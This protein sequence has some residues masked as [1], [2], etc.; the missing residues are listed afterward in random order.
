M[1]GTQNHEIPTQRAHHTSQSKTSISH[2]NSTSNIT[3]TSISTAPTPDNPNASFNTLGLSAQVMMS[4]RALHYTTPTPV[5][6]QA[7]PAILEGR[8]VCAAA[9]TGTGKTAA[10]LL[11][12]LTHLPHG[13]HIRLP[14][15][16]G[17]TR[18]NTQNSRKK[19]G[20]GV[21][22]G[23]SSCNSKQHNNT[24][25]TTAQAP[26]L[27]DAATP[28]LLVITPT[29]ELAEQIGT[30]CATICRNT[31]HHLAV[32]YGG[33]KYPPQI[34]KLRCGVDILI[35]TPGR[36]MDLRERGVIDLSRVST[37]VLDEADRMLDM[38]FWPAVQSIIADIPPTRQTLLFSATLDKKILAKIQPI[39]HNPVRIEIITHGDTAKTVDQ[40]ILP[41][42]HSQ[43]QELLHALLMEKGFEKVIVFART[44]HR[45]EHC[46]K[47][48]QREKFRAE[49][50]HSDKSQAN[51]RKALENF[52]K[53][54]TNILVATDVLARGIDVPQV[55]YVVNF[56]LPDFPDD[57]IHRIGRTG[58]AGETGFAVSF[59]S[60]ESVSALRQIQRLIHT[61]LPLLPL[62]TVHID[63]AILEEQPNHV[64]S[65][66]RAGLRSDERTGGRTNRHADGRA[67][68]HAGRTRMHFTRAN[69]APVVLRE[70][71]EKR[72]RNAAY[73]DSSAR[74]GS[75][76]Q[77]EKPSG[78]KNSTSHNRKPKGAR[79][80]N[81][82]LNNAPGSNPRSGKPKGTRVNST[83]SSGAKS[84]HPKGSKAKNTHLNGERGA[85]AK[86]RN[87]R[88]NHTSAKGT[89]S[90]YAA[91]SHYAQRSAKPQRKR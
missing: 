71:N 48:L 29:R 28:S 7:I 88:S 4:L 17:T 47:I 6:Q 55:N 63:A 80:K 82:T 91:S 78:G 44:K 72:I 18:A 13:K 52:S 70:R 53:G 31:Q 2:T 54:K 68:E 21:K 16:Q 9:A 23:S 32:V 19:N 50:I 79:F 66:L 43:K 58:R 49:S 15:Q 76:Q 38:G 62:E 85:G 35:A 12:V 65:G 33:T 8:D 42:Q 37:L 22:N 24:P 75:N 40:Y 74:T 61:E 5:Q 77:R 83:Q 11:P 3:S 34:T 46:C 30:T 39:L 51:R 14:K 84:T 27:L 20:N 60:P 89:R 26:Q 64:R 59:V 36:L 41:V 90:N 86:A 69:K 81:A 10:F 25:S 87:A 56:D 45:A 67:D 73:K 1:S 57:Y